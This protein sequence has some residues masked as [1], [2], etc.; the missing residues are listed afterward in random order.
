MLEIVVADEAHARLGSIPDDERRAT[1]VETN[2]AFGFDGVADDGDGAFSLASLVV[3]VKKKVVT[4][5]GGEKRTA[6]GL[7]D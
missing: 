7:I 4:G 5:S 6:R 1:R 3:V 2:H